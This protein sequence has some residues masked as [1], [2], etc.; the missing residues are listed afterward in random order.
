MGKTHSERFVTLVKDALNRVEEITPVE[1]Q[2]KIDGEEFT[3]IDV[4]EHDEWDSSRIVNAIHL[5]K[6]VIER[7]IEDEMPNQDE[8]LVL[9]CEDGY[10]SALAADNLKRMG[11]RN[12][13]LLKGG[14]RAWNEAGLPIE[15][16]EA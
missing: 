11:Y 3:L 5:G 8:E 14:F 7:D 13:K 16:E 12:V 2:E 9:Y 10:R 6:G 1:V 15:K 4:R